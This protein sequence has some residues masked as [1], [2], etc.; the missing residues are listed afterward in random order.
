MDSIVA[1]NAAPL[2]PWDAVICTSEAVLVSVQQLLAAQEAYLRERLGSTRVTLPQLP[3][4]PL[5]IHSE[6]FECS[7]VDR[8]AA[9]QSLA[10]DDDAL[11][12]MFMGSLSFQGK[13]HPLAM[14]Q[15]LERSAQEA[16]VRVV[17]V[18]CGWHGDEIIRAAGELLQTI[19]ANRRAQMLRGLTWLITLDLLCP[20]AP[21]P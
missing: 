8:Q 21:G 16:G 13:A 12:V 11:V 15:A 19:P 3:L 20:T 6:D 5:G 9:R 14:D 1:F 18:E 10:V 7:A 4:I 2:H 17:L